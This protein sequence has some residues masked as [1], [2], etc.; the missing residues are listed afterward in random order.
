MQRL[1]SVKNQKGVDGRADLFSL[2]IMAYRMLT[3][4]LADTSSTV[5]PPSELNPAI[6]P[7]WDDVILKSISLNP[8]HRFA[9]AQEMR[10]TV[11]AVNEFGNASDS[12]D[13]SNDLQIIR[14]VGYLSGVCLRG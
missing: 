2:G 10:L 12:G 3:G 8:D 5:L 7:V 1:S 13:G 6:S 11:E 14:P 4:Q 9:S